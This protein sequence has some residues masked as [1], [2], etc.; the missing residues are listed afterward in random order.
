[1]PAR[2]R[3]KCFTLI[4][5]LVALTLLISLLGLAGFNIR[6]A[7]QQQV[8][9]SEGDNLIQH[10]RLAQEILLTLH[11]ESEL[12]FT[13]GKVKWVPVGSANKIYDGM[14]EKTKIPLL[15]FSEIAF[16]ETGGEKKN[17]TFTLKF[18]DDGYVMSRGILSLKSVQDEMIYILLPGYPA[19]L[20][21]Q[22]EPPDVSKLVREEN[23]L[24]ERLTHMTLSDVQN[25]K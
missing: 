19:P 7:W 12:E 21:L 24:F 8:F 15:A 4:E 9:R 3:S 6:K 13:P 18:L 16:Q 1:M 14:I 20:S 11:I 2:T 22:K 17:G 25:K 10:L 5:I 23:E